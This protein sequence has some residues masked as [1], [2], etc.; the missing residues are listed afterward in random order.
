VS[1]RSKTVA[2]FD[3]VAGNSEQRHF[4]AERLGFF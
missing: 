1:N 3:H 2:L 4:E